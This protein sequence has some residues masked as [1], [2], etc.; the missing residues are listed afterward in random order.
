MSEGADITPVGGEGEDFFPPLGDGAH[1]RGREAHNLCALWF[2]LRAKRADRR[3]TPPGA[4]TSRG[5]SS[6]RRVRASMRPATGYAE[7]R[8]GARR[9]E[10]VQ[11]P[12]QWEE[13]AA[14][15]IHPPLGQ[16]KAGSR[17][18]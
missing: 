8:P 18:A 16:C 10:T 9:L 2:H 15:G 4:P 11:L 5:V 12:R 14:W 1:P 17:N 13:G 6:S 3:N 7:H